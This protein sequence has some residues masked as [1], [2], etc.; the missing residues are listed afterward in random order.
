MININKNII[1]IGLSGCGK[2]TIGDLLAKKLNMDFVDIDKYIE[3]KEG[4]TI[5]DIFEYGEDY[6]REIESKAVEEV[7]K[8]SSTVISTGG[9][10][11]KKF[12][13][14]EILN[15]NGIIIFINRSAEDII[16]DIDV[17]IRPLLKDGK[18]K[19]HKLYEERYHLYKKYCDYEIVN[20]KELND[21]VDTIIDC[22]CKIK[23]FS[24]NESS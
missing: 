13:N 22:V 3:E 9:G 21:V 7:S 10:V 24:E 16:S 1:L 12:S 4:K 14:I 11:I 17:S 6:F 18:E 15:K 5:T 20:N 23:G 8:I 2:T 19:I